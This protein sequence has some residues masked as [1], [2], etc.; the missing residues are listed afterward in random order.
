MTANHKK[1]FIVG[2]TGQQGGAVTQSLLRQGYQVRALVRAANQKSSRAEALKSRGVE[3][4]TGDMTDQASLEQAM[5]G[6]DGVFAMTTFFEAGLD[7]EIQQ[8]VIIAEAAK[9]ANVPHLVYS[10]VGSAHRNTGVPHFESKWKVEQHIRQLG[11]PTTTIRPAYFMENFST[12]NRDAIL[13]GALIIPMHPGTKLQM[14]A[15]ADIGEFGA[16]ALTRPSDF[17]GQGI[18]LA[19]DELTMEDVAEQLSNKLK[20]PVQFTSFPDDQ[21]EGAMGPDMASMFRWFNEVGYCADIQELKARYGI[22]LTSF[23]E[24]IGKIDWAKN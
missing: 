18:E 16:A 20:R 15:V 11:I 24:F 1:F 4:V 10:S 23:E 7:A 17:L 19:G 22:P 5:A 9:K 6:V 21:V 8:G 12:F 3:V 14:I 2:A 13:Q